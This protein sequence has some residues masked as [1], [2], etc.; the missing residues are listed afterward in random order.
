M[1]AIAM[2]VW[3]CG[4]ECERTRVEVSDQLKSH[5][6]LFSGWY[7]NASILMHFIFI[8]NMSCRAMFIIIV[9][10]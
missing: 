7:G 6:F 1:M 3:L 4:L 9:A 10:I 8:K 5:T 2:I